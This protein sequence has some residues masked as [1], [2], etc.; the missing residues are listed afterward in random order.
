MME[1]LFY[2]FSGFRWQDALDILLNSYILFRLYVLFRGT[3]VIRVLLAFC[4]LWIASQ[5]AVPLGLIITNWAKQ[6]VITVAALI[7]IIVFRNEISSVLQTKNLKSFLWGIPRYQSHT[8]LNIIIESVYEL[9]DKKIGALIVLPLKQG[10]DSIVQGGV[11]INGKLSQEM[12]VSIFWPGNPLHD[13]AAVIQ[14]DW[15]TSA[16]V[17]LPLSKRKDLPSSFGTRHRAAS[18]LTELSDALVI[19]VSEERGKISLFK[20]NKT[21]NIHN[22][23]GLKKSLR[24]HTGDDSTKKGFRHQTM[25]LAAAALISL[26]CITGI[27]FNFSKGMETLATYEVPVEFM[28]P[29]QKMEIISSSAS[30]VKVLISGAK[31]LINSI[32]SDQINIKLNLSQSVV[33]INKLS[34][35]KENIVLPPGI[36]LKKIDPSEL[37]ITLDILLEKE[38]PVQPNWIGKLPEGLIMK[39]AKAL[40]QTIRV[41]GGGLALKNISTIYTEKILLDKITE[42][43]TATVGLVLNPASLRLKNNNKIQIEYLILKKST[44]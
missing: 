13:G 31:P 29:D 2:L 9:A 36:R 8:P 37:D 14:G 6:G 23:S 30:N 1:T 42:S 34:I 20:E 27:W 11:P 10:L 32:K 16:G 7:I 17:I 38:I 25:E 12:L 41:T 15:I 33:G 5:A 22:R 44:L 43:G 19:V 26:F 3:N 18:G 28:N 4:L 21:L 39:E 24:E 35:T 40:P